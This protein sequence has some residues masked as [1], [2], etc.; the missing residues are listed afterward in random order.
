MIYNTVFFLNPNSGIPLY[1]QLQQ[2][3]RQR[4]LSGQ[5]AHGAQLPSVR[6]LSAELHIN[7]LT[8][9]KV[10]Q[11]LE[12]EGFVETKRGTG[13]YVAHES[14]GLRMDARRA[15]IGPAVEQL[16]A[17]ALHLGLTEKDVQV[18]LSEKFRQFKSKN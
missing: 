9:A 3:I 16:V 7:P 1:V 8:V 12:R 13:T 15:E 14:P 10:Y 4:I 5:L 2:Q 6:E 11:L 18:L 17:E